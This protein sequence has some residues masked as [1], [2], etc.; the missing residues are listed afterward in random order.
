MLHDE[1][2]SERG[3]NL[4]FYI[5]QET[6]IAKCFIIFKWPHYITPSSCAHLIELNCCCCYRPTEGQKQEI[7]L[8][9]S[10]RRVVVAISAQAKSETITC[11]KNKGVRT[12][13]FCL[14]NP[15][16]HLVLILVSCFLV[17]SSALFRLQADVCN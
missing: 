2:S 8:V 7:V 16:I 13:I 12:R 4:S 14:I 3:F 15:F 17:S 11:N 6:T 10:K 9:I 5:L 1:R